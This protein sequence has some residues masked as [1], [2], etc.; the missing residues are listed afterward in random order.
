MLR[1]AWCADD[2]GY[3]QVSNR[4]LQKAVKVTKRQLVR[5]IGQ[6]AGDGEIEVIPR[7]DEFGGSLPNAY[8]IHKRYISNRGTSKPIKKGDPLRDHIA[9]LED[10]VRVLRQKLERKHKRRSAG[11]M[12]RAAVIERDNATC[13]YCG[14]EVPEEDI[15]IDHVYPYSKGGYT[16]VDNLVVACPRCNIVKGD[17]IGIWPLTT[18]PFR[19]A[20]RYINKPIGNPPP[21]HFAIP[22]E[23]YGIGLDPFQF[24]MFTHFCVT[25]NPQEAL[26]DIAEKCGMSV[27]KA[28]QVRRELEDMGLLEWFEYDENGEEKWISK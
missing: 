5:L 4:D 22:D 16:V 24:A 7:F 19:T 13:R 1:L 2:N 12:M 11:R 3:A 18:N 15:H 6:L 9:E 21:G 20:N 27:G 26:T 25:G 23:I 14:V 28:S 10:E 17:R 8:K